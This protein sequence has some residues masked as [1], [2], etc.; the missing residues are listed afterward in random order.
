M[1]GLGVGATALLCISHITP[2]RVLH[3]FVWR[4]VQWGAFD[5]SLVSM[6]T[7]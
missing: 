4:M 6:F 3:V 2:S 5:A 1:C 7:V